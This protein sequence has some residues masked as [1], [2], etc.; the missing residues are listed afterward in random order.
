MLPT[1]IVSIMDVSVEAQKV[2]NNVVKRYGGPS[3]V[4]IGTGLL[5]GVKFAAMRE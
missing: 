1:V 5:N 3:K 2:F 4:P